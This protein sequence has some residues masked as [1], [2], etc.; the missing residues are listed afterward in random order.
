MVNIKSFKKQIPSFRHKRIIN[1]VDNSFIFHKKSQFKSN[2]NLIKRVKKLYNTRTLN[3]N[4][5]LLKYTNIVTQTFVYNFKPYKKIIACQTFSN[6][7][8]Y[9]PGLEYLNVGKIIYNHHNLLKLANQYWF[10]G[11]ITQLKHLPITAIFS[12]VTNTYNNK[13]TYAKAGGTYCKLK[14]MKKTK[15]KLTEVILPSSKTIY[16]GHLNK[17]YVGRNTDFTIQQLNEGKYGFG[18]HKYKNIKVRGV[19]MNPVD[20]PNGGRTK[21]VQPERSPWNWIAKK[22]K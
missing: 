14:K 5:D 19:A 18:F 2:N 3:I 21:T 17:A 12:N 10:V 22:K 1:I 16:L 9:I 7:R 11:F 6:C 13:I 4:L 15:K 20:H 8:V